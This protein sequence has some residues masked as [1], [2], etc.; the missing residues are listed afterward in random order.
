MD[1]LKYFLC[2][3]YAI[4]VKSGPFIQQDG[5]PFS[6]RHTSG[7]SLVRI[8]VTTKPTIYNISLC[9]RPFL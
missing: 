1:S 9:V 2:L 5:V 7:K 4:V 8:S 3:N 6:L